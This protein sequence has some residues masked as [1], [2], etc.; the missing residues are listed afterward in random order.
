[1]FDYLCRKWILVIGLVW[2]LLLLLAGIMRLFNLDELHAAIQLAN[3][4][5]FLPA[6]EAFA[7]YS[8]HPII[9]ALLYGAGWISL[10]LFLPL[11]V[12]GI[13]RYGDYDRLLLPRNRPS[14]HPLKLLASVILAELAILWI[15][16]N[17]HGTT[18]LLRNRHGMTWLESTGFFIAFKFLLLPIGLAFSVFI[19]KNYLKERFRI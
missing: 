19:A 7:E 9:T 11:T 2:G 16:I 15:T 18:H 12:A 1:M 17:P 5:K 14:L 10:P 8:D 13:L 3:F 6:V 4:A